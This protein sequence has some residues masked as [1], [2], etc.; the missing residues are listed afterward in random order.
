MPTSFKEWNL[1]GHKLKTLLVYPRYPD[2]FWSFRHTMKFIGKKANF[3]PLGLLTAAAMLPSEWEKRLVDMNVTHLNDEDIKWADLVFISAMVVQ[4]ESAKEVIDRC[5]QFNIQVA[6]GGPLFTTEPEQFR[7]VE[8]LVLNE[9]EITLPLFLSDLA[10]QK[11]QRIYTTTEH[12]DIAK[13]PIPSWSLIDMSKYWSM[14]LQY[15]RG[16]PF[17]CEFCEIG[18]LDGHDPRTKDREQILSE[19]DSLYNNRWRGH[20]F[21]VDDNF[22]GR[23]YRVANQKKLSLR[24]IHR[25]L[26][27]PGR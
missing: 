1:K 2:T 21:I 5:H 23:T 26:Y 15:S 7:M 3:P 20:I 18:S 11:P 10:K 4:K 24:V 8:Y 14:S 19:L 27:Q 9:A 17:N 22:I 16:C 12:P 25:G 13:T 6:A